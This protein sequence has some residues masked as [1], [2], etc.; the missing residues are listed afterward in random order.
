M[1]Y[2]KLSERLADDAVH[3]EPVSDQIPCKQEFYKEFRKIQPYSA[4]SSSVC[5]LIAKANRLSSF[6]ITVGV[7]VIR[8]SRVRAA[9]GAC[10]NEQPPMTFD[11]GLDLRVGHSSTM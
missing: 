1:I 6:P 7:S 3:V 9:S 11:E 5:S 2:L 10:Q 8:N 4:S